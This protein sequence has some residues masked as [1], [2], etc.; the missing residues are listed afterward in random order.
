MHNN[1]G[2]SLWQDDCVKIFVGS[3]GFGDTQLLLYYFYLTWVARTTSGKRLDRSTW[4][5]KSCMCRLLT[6]WCNLIHTSQLTI[7]KTSLEGLGV[8]SSLV[9]KVMS[10]EIV[11]LEKFWRGIKP[12]RMITLYKVL[13]NMNMLLATHPVWKVFN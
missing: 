9:V 1:C 12:R 4:P 3:V 7:Y 13:W 5:C 10:L 6:T 11:S 8:L 2:R